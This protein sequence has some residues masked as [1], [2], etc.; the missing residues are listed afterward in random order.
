LGFLLQLVR[1]DDAGERVVMQFGKAEQDA[2]ILDFNPT[3]VCH[4]GIC[5]RVRPGGLGSGAGVMEMPTC[6]AHESQQT[7]RGPFKCCCIAENAAA[8]GRRAAAVL[9]AVEAFGV[10][11]S[12]FDSKLFL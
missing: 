9:T 1:S 4:G 11:L 6:A 8:A 2:F 10:V 7:W 5:L 3:G 12:T